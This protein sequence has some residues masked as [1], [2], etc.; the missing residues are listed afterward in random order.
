MK[1][2][3]SEILDGLDNKV[4]ENNKITFASVLQDTTEQ[5]IESVLEN[6][7]NLES[8]IATNEGQLDLHYV[9]T[10]L[11]STGWNRNDDV[12][13]VQETWLARKT[14][15]DKPFNYEHNPSDVIG[16]IT[17]NHV[18]DDYGSVVDDSVP[19]ESLPNKF[20]IVTSGVLY[21]QLSSR[22]PE[23]AERMEEI[24]QGIKNGEWFVSMEAL[25]S[26]FDYALIK[27]DGFEKVIGRS[28]ESAFLTKH[29]RSYGGTGEYQ[30]YKVGRVIKNITFSG[31]GLVRKPANPDS[32]FIFNDDNVF[33]EAKLEIN[34]NAFCLQENIIMANDNTNE[35]LQRE[36]A[37]LQ[38]R[39]KEMDEAAVT[40]KFKSLE[41]D[42][43]DR[44]A[45]LADMTEACQ[46]SDQKFSDAEAK[47][48]DLQSEVTSLT[49]A[50][51]EVEKELEAIRAEAA[52]AVRL[53]LLTTSGLSN[54]EAEETIAK[55]ANLNDE[56]FNAVVEF[57]TK[58]KSEEAAEAD[59]S[60]ETE[61]VAEEDS[62]EKDPAEDTAEADALE[63]A[64]D[65]D[66][67]TLAVAEESSNDIMD[68]LAE[69]LET[70]LH[71]ETK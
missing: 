47:A 50:K 61:A 6:C 41:A 69:Y 1:I 54:E 7:P 55:F 24:I 21:R 38:L 39:L 44:D 51:E 60:E 68:S 56:Q 70:S 63:D 19:I 5:N 59:V 15:E 37:E 52:K 28:E 35:T 66:E 3:K 40:A 46:S 20:H 49:E 26:D 65:S 16:H 10:V 18:I 57:A 25:F 67:A 34:N 22:D 2:Y 12:F 71:G 23:L 9:N 32:V 58:A 36:I 45:K 62:D 14:P 4:L 53:A 31:K 27:P 43:A 48:K 11:V 13:D 64:E 33:S 42:I 30:G 8:A 29:L 17:S